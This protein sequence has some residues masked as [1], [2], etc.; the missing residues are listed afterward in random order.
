MARSSAAASSEFLS[1]AALFRLS[2]PSR[3]VTRRD[4]LPHDP[5]DYQNYARSRADA[6]ARR[7]CDSRAE[8]EHGKNSAEER[9]E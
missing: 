1:A 8:Q 2:L 7:D 3:H 4:E 9:Y 6:S 5:D